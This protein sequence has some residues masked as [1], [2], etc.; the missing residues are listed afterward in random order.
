MTAAKVTVSTGGQPG[1]LISKKD[2][3][4]T[5]G[6]TQRKLSYWQAEGIFSGPVLYKGQG[7]QSFFNRVQWSA[8][9]AL[10][11]LQIECGQ[12]IADIRQIIKRMQE[13][14]PDSYFMKEG[15]KSEPGL[16]LYPLFLQFRTLADNPNILE[17]FKKGKKIFSTNA[18][19]GFVD[20][21]RH[22]RRYTEIDGNNLKIIRKDEFAPGWFI[23][24]TPI[25][26]FI[27]EVVESFEGLSPDLDSDAEQDSDNK[28]EVITALI[29]SSVIFPP[30]YYYNGKKFYSQ[31]DVACAAY[32]TKFAVMYGLEKTSTLLTRIKEDIMEFFHFPEACVE[33]SASFLRFKKHV[34][35]IIAATNEFTEIEEK[36]S[37]C[38]EC[39]F[40]WFLEGKIRMKPNCIDNGIMFQNANT[41]E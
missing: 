27:L 25:T 14:D 20:L 21:E 35:L 29:E 24:A 9:K 8:A 5:V 19:K 4:L 3:L 17:E 1:D 12:S 28:K 10:A 37:D 36:G 16:C 7:G 11:F 23:E 38:N 26:N 30:P 2:F 13:D 31:T 41:N 33:Y 40:E 22:D 6:I 39:F 18:R 34:E 32:F 15:S